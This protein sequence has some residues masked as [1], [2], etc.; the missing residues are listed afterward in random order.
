MQNSVKFAI[1]FHFEMS[2]STELFIDVL[3]FYFCF[4]LY[5]MQVRNAMIRTA[6]QELGHGLS[7]SG[8]L[9]RLTS[10]TNEFCKQ[11]LDCSVAPL[12]YNE[13]DEVTIPPVPD[14]SSRLC[15]FCE[16]HEAIV[17]LDCG[18]QQLCCDCFTTYARQYTTN[19]IRLFAPSGNPIVNAEN[20]L[21]CPHCRVDVKYYI[22]ARR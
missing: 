14:T 4:F 18:C 13:I 21:K 12:D 9:D 15:Q 6:N 16:E 19:G 11:I 20:P 1:E 3:I 5:L 22:M 8:F 10:K 2:C 17:T 7:V